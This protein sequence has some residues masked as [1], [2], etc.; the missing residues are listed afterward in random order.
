V[1]GAIV[2]VKKQGDIVAQLLP[3]EKAGGRISEA[4]APLASMVPGEPN[5]GPVVSLT[6]GG[7]PVI[8]AMGPPPVEMSGAGDFAGVDGGGSSASSPPPLSGSGS[9]PPLSQPGGPPPLSRSSAP[10]PLSGASAPPLPDA[11]EV[12][13]PTSSLGGSPHSAAS[14]NGAGAKP[15]V[16]LPGEPVESVRAPV[17]PSAAPQGLSEPTPSSLPLPGLSAAP[18]PGSVPASSDANKK[19]IAAYL[20]GIVSG[21]IISGM[22]L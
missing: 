17:A 6:D 3:H 2:E 21:L 14:L 15:G 9:P 1:C 19:M 4:P 7:R 13:A 12:S 20:A 5:S 8:P 16:S 10:P 11:A 22:F 18:A